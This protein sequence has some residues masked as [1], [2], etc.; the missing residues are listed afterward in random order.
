MFICLVVSISAPAIIIG[1]TIA[2]MRK[3]SS[4]LKSKPKRLHSITTTN[5]PQETLKAIVRFAQQSNYHLSF[6]DEI[7][8]QTV[9]EDSPSLTSWGFFYPIFISQRDDKTTLIEVGI[10]SKLVQI[11]PIVSIHHQR[12]INGI[13]AALFLQK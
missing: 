9:L 13:K 5:N 3:G 10:K 4:A 11:G 7:K 2:S 1:C 6:I 8:Y 12:C